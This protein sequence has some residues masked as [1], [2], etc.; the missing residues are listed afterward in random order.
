MISSVYLNHETFPEDRKPKIEVRRYD[1]EK[2]IEENRKNNVE[3]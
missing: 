3:F 2:N 1:W